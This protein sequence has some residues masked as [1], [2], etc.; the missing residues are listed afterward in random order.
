MRT[1]LAIP[2]ATADALCPL[3][4]PRRYDA[5]AYRFAPHPRTCGTHGWCKNSGPRAMAVRHGLQLCRRL[6]QSDEAQADQG[7]VPVAP[8]ARPP[9]SPHDHDPALRH[10]TDSVQR[11][12][13]TRADT[14][15]PQSGGAVVRWRTGVDAVATV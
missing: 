8:C 10:V 7:A 14:I 2:V 1:P 13:G 9:A 5:T 11:L 15:R 4:Q 3:R 6:P 12:C